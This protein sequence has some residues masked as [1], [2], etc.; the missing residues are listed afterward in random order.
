MDVDIPKEKFVIIGSDESKQ[1]FIGRPKISYMKDAWRRLK[2]NKTAMAA[3]IMLCALIF[4]C[5]FGPAI[6]GHAFE[7]IN[8]QA[9][10]QGPSGANWFGTDRLGRDLFAR[11][12]IGG[13]VSVVI[14]ISAALIASIIGTLYG[15]IC[16]Y[17]GGMV[18]VVLMRIL[19]IFASVPQLII[20]V[21]LSIVLGNNSIGTILIALSVA[22]W[23][24]PARLVR[25]QMLQI[26]NQEFIL[27][28]QV[29]GVSSRRI[30]L[31]HMIPNTLS[32]VIVAITFAVPGFIFAEAFLSFIGL[33]VQPPDTS[34]GALV[35]MAQ[36]QFRFF[37]YQMFFPAI[38]IAL[39]MLSFTLF[40]DGLRDALDPRLRK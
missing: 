22:S 12:W 28:A 18:D 40:G 35:A 39:T 27:A 36:S 2:E 16:A 34:W 33:G 24:G 20:V 19:E 17:F 4:L 26:R 1:E 14:G 6:S 7:E 21:I 11:V 38:M 29:L 9:R 3:L 13:R 8:A 15:G 32:V 30:I 31:R 10:N 37:P 5:V 25:G 23:V